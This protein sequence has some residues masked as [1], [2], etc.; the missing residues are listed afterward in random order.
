MEVPR[1][2]STEAAARDARHAVFATST[3][4]V[5]ALAHNRDDQAETLLLQ[6]LRGAGPRGLA[7]M[8][9][10]RQG[11]PGYWRPLLDVPRSEIEA[12][13]RR[14]GLSWV[15]DDSN[16]DRGYLRNF[17]RHE[18]LPLI[19]SRVPA[20]GVVL[21]RAARVQAEASELLDALAVQDLGAAPQGRSIALNLLKNIPEYRAR[22]VLRYFLR[23]ND[24]AMPDAVRLE[25][26]LRQAMTARTDARVC[27]NIGDV[28]LRRFRDCLHVV[29]PLP[30]V[31][32]DF[33]MAWNR[34]KPLHLPQLGGTLVLQSCPDG[35]IAGQWLQDQT[36][37]V[38]I[39]RGG[40]VMRLSRKGP[41][42][43]VRNLLQEAALPPWQR[44]RLPLI[45]IDG[46]LAAVPGIGVDER[47]RAGAGRR[48]WL[49]V[50]RPD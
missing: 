32:A 21:A 11:K 38:R 10:F 24:V 36:L 19:Q 43:T 49:P 18:V 50:W 45:H 31:A 9:P 44:E 7:A 23:R 26:A 47:F 4:D 16:L 12:Y 46:V 42:R 27:V 1:G 37:T 40:E 41:A 2:N 28:E 25:E 29:R 14:H 6:L 13:A 35:G 34:R 20:A 17:L 30:G 48:G 33:E 22:N 3:A 15:E 5:V 39:R 8:A